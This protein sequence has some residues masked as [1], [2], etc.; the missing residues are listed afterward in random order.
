MKKAIAVILT[1]SV[2]LIFNSVVF[3]G[4]YDIEFK[5]N[6]ERILGT[7]FFI[8]LGILLNALSILCYNMFKDLLE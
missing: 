2:C 4:Y 6:I 7:S 1:L 3:A 5:D 8:G